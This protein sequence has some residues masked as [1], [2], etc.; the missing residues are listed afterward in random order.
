[1]LNIMAQELLDRITGTFSLTLSGLVKGYILTVRAEGKSPH[2]IIFY[3]SILNRFMWYAQA[4]G[5]PENPQEINRFHIT[6]FLSYVQNEP[7]RWGGTS[8]T[9]CRPANETTVRHYYRTLYTFFGW[10]HIEGFITENPVA[11]IKTP[12]AAHKVIQ[13]LTDGEIR[14]LLAQCPQKTQLGCR[15]R[16]ILLMFLD[17]GMRVS[18]L[19]NLQPGDIDM[20]TG[21]ILI[22]QGKGRKQRIVRIGSTTLKALWRY[23][24]LYRKGESEAVFLSKTGDSLQAN[25]IEIMVRKLGQKAGVPGVHAHRLRHTFAISFLRAGGDIFTL[26]HL[27]GHSSLTMVENYLKS[28]SSE[29][30]LKAHE[31]YSPVNKLNLK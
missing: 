18:E 2:T 31:K 27:L 22:T 20:D 4:H 5:F 14:K 6:E 19:A 28:L 23:M 17:T 8:N 26:K 10:C 24:Q 30:A 29:D 25:G 7:I 16:A 11:P 1:M 15:D 9:A 3:E 21:S 13:A 12:K